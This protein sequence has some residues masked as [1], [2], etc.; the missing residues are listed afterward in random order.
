MAENIKYYW[1]GS[2]FMIYYLNGNI[3]TKSRVYRDMEW[4]A[5][6]EH[7]TKPWD[8]FGK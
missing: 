3:C 7:K 4:I 8:G 6:T 2:Q 5:G 1:S